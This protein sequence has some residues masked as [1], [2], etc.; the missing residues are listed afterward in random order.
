MTVCDAAE[1]DEIVYDEQRYRH[2]SGEKCP[3]CR[4]VKELT[5][6]DERIKELEN[7]E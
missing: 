7:A 6:K 4:M 1:H 3:M 5:Q 2:I